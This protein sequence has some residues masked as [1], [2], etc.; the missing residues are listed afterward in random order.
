MS[1]TSLLVKKISQIFKPATM[2]ETKKTESVS[3]R[4]G[5]TIPVN[6][7]SNALEKSG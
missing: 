6:R 1:A 2:T 7:M 4:A 5:L 3:E